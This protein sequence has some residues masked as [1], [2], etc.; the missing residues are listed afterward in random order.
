M[1]TAKGNFKSSY[2]ATDLTGRP[3]KTGNTVR[4]YRQHAIKQSTIKVRLTSSTEV[5]K[6]SSKSIRGL[7]DD[8]VHGS[9]LSSVAK[10]RSKI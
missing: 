10:I 8:L 2:S 9:I 7:V 5:S 6:I 3:D 4:Y 1:C